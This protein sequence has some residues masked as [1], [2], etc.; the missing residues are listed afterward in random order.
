MGNIRGPET[1]LYINQSSLLIL[2]LV[3]LNS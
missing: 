1:I 2:E 3:T